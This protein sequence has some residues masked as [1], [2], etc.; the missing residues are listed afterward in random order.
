MK[1]LLLILAL[2][3]AVPAQA[4]TLSTMQM[5]QVKALIR[6]ANTEGAS[7]VQA[8]TFAASS[9]TLDTYWDVQT[10]GSNTSF[11]RGLASRH[12]NGELRFLSGTHTGLLQEFRPG[13]TPATGRITAPTNQWNISAVTGDFYGIFYE[14]AKDRLWVSASIDYGDS[15]TYYPSRISTLTLNADGTVSNVKTVSL[16]GVTSKRIYGGVLAVPAAINTA[17]GGKC[18]YMVG[19][20]G[21]TSLA[22]QVSRAA[23]GPSVICIP[24]IAGYA[25]GAVIPAGAF[26]VLL[27]TPTDQRGTRVT[28]PDNY[29]DGG[30]ANAQGVRRENPQTPPTSAPYAGAAWLSPNTV[31]SQGPIG[32][33]L[34]VWGDSYYNNAFFNGNT[35]VLVAAVCGG[36]CWYQ[37]STLHFDT[38]L[39]EVHA[40]D[41]TKLGSNTMRRPDS[42]AELVLPRGIVGSWDGDVPM[43]NISGVTVDSATGTPYAIG[44]P[45]GNPSGGPGGQ[46]DTGRLYRLKIGTGSTPPPVQ[47]PPPPP[48]PV[49]PPPVTPP[50]VT[51]PPTA[52]VFSLTVDKASVLV[53]QAYTLSVATDANQHNVMLD[54]AR[55][56]C[57]PCAV[58]MPVTKTAAGTFAH[59]LAATDVSGTARSPVT[60]TVKVTAPAP[61]PPSDPCVANPA[62]LVV[63]AWPSSAEGSTQLRYSYAVS[64]AVATVK[65]V[66]LTFGPT[67]LT[68]R[69]SRGCTVVKVN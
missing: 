69:D 47:P 17:L 37:N 59:T 31:A 24:D 64:G 33:N 67:T 23:M 14:E 52:A 6:S 18:P 1:R 28:R 8:Q 25:D 44:F 57:G 10:F 19:W 45:L 26:K 38:R 34:F 43:A 42:M 36:K 27:D 61:P 50:P 48:P 11:M 29:F 53:G 41:G 13:S 60:V 51:P 5:A 68:V 21:Y 46:W 16:E 56:N 62:A 7:G 4:Q 35:L 12:V 2:V 65:S 63:S 40:W 9:V 15:G 20:G 30:D 49:E 39:Q 22:Q 54:G 32:A 58:T 66:A 55:L 3:F